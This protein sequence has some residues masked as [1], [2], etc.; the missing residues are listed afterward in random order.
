MARVMIDDLWLKDAEDGTP[1][2][3]QARRALANAKDPMRARVPDKWKTTR[4][5]QGRRWRCRWYMP[6]NG[7]KIQKSKSFTKYTEAEE[8]RAAMED[9]V[10]RGRYHDPHQANRLFHDVANEWVH[11]KLDVKTSTRTRY[12]GELRVYINPRWGDI[13]L[14][15]INRQDIQQWVESLTVGNYPANLPRNR[16]PRALK[17]RSIRSIVRIVMGGVLEYAVEQ[18]WIP[19]NPMR[20]V[21][22]PRIVNNDDDRIYLTIPEVELLADECEVVSGNP[23]DALLVRFL[24]Y[25]G[26]RVNE[27]LALKASDVDLAHGRVRV[28]RTWTGDGKGGQTLDVP[29]N[30][31]PRWAAMPGFLTS[32][33]RTLID[34][35]SDD[36]WVFRAA[37]GGSIWL[38]NWRSRVWNPAVRNAGM[39]D[40]GI[41]IHSLRH[42]YASIAIA[43]GADVKTLQQQLGHSSATITLDTYAALW[44][45]RLGEVA[46]AVGSMVEANMSDTIQTR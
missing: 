5:G 33:L 18:Q 31:K 12:E 22:T 13:P 30:G 24:A 4:Y 23:T 21:T 38:P 11:S 28:S 25:T 27:A 15:A 37:R 9:D 7:R 2:S 41:V 42:T 6:V 35:Q 39:E 14:R 43:A 40:E 16:A 20:G 45:E 8:F 34:G 44:P 1:P 17:P 3:S 10:R 19:V 32:Q 26:L 36:T 46:D 29:K